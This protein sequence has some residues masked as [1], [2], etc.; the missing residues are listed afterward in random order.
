MR[1]ESKSVVFLCLDTTPVIGGDEEQG[2]N[3]RRIQDLGS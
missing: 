2:G 1:G 3:K